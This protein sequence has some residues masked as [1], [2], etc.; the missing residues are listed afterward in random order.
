MQMKPIV[1]MP[2]TPYYEQDGIV[3]YNGDAIKVLEFLEADC[4]VTDPPYGIAYETNWNKERTRP[5]SIVNDGDTD[6]R[7]KALSMISCPAMVFGS[8]KKP[9]PFNAKFRMIWEKCGSSGMGDLSLPWRPNTEDIFL[10]G[11]GWFQV[12]GRESSVIRFDALCGEQRHPNEKPPALMRYLLQRCPGGSILDPFMG[13]G[14]T[15]VAAKLEGRQ[16]VGIEINEA[17][18]EIAANRLSQGVLF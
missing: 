14:T 11:G 5:R 8:W 18:C 4:V 1:T 13:S 16:A 3:I 15:L 9:A 2:F 6:L 12:S 17:Y 7:D 10:I